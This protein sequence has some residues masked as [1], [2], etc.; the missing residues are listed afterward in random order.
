MRR[1]R[2]RTAWEQVTRASASRRSKHKFSDLALLQNAQHGGLLCA[3]PQLDSQ[4]PM[5]QRMAQQY[6]SKGV[7]TIGLQEC[8]VFAEA[9]L[10]HYCPDAPKPDASTLS[11]VSIG[12]GCGAF[13]SLLREFCSGHVHIVGVDPAPLSFDAAQDLDAPFVEPTYA[14]AAEVLRPDPCLL[15]FNWC[16]PNDSTYDAEALVLLKPEAFLVVYEIFEGGS[17]AAGSRS[18]FEAIHGP[19]SAYRL[20]GQIQ[21]VGS[22]YGPMGPVTLDMRMQWWE[23]KDTER[24]GRYDSPELQEV[25]DQGCVLS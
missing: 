2:Y 12:S 8:L 25:G 6:L 10:K 11:L 21:G 22:E 5:A 18:F 17:G 1:A 19:A 23:L 14:T 24:P 15:L 20:V 7:E 3:A 9:F 16:A 4:S 13:E